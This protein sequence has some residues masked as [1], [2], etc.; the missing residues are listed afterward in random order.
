[1]ESMQPLAGVDGCAAGWLAVRREA[2]GRIVPLVAF[3]AAD[4]FDR[5][6]D[7]AV[8]AI[9]IPIGIPDAGARACD[10]AARALLGKPRSNSVFPCP[11]RGALGAASYAE[12]CAVTEAADGRKIS[13]QAYAIIPKIRELDALLRER[14]ELRE[15]VVEVHPELSFHRWN[16]DRPMV[17]AKK[18][19]EGK[20]ER[21]ALIDAR[22]PGAVE[23]VRRRF[24]VGVVA[25]DDIHDALAAL[26]SAE[27][28]A[29]GAALV[30]GGVET[31]AFGIPMRMLV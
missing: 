14:P 22:Y 4:L 7:C 25:D 29:T 5:C 11:V 16:G 20:A 8:A 24:P 6:A 12:A 15:W 3:T 31:D 10:V 21:R 9:D 1:M 30:T 17:H 23:D 19:A 27:R 18:T 28:I 26:W 13:Q 2:D